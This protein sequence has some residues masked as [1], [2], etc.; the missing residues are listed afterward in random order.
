MYLDCP[1]PI[2]IERSNGAGYDQKNIK[3]MTV[4]GD[5]MSDFGSR[6]A[7]M[8]K[9]V[10]YPHSC[11]A[12][13]GSTFNHSNNNWQTLLRQSVGVFSQNSSCQQIT[14]S[15]IGGGPSLIK[16]NDLN[17]SYAFGGALTGRNTYFDVLNS[18]GQFPSKLLKPPYAV[19]K[20]GIRSQ[21]EHSFQSESPD[22]S[23]QLA[24]IWG[25]GN[26]LLAAVVRQQDLSSAFEQILNNSKA[27]LI[28]LLRNSN[29]KTVLI[30]SGAPT[31]GIVDGVSYALPY[32]RD[33]PL[34]WQEQIQSGA[35]S[36]LHDKT[37]QMAE[38]VKKM[39][40]YATII[41]FNNE[42]E[43]NWNRFG[44]KLGNFRQYGIINTTDPAQQQALL[45]QKDGILYNQLPYAQLNHQC[46][47]KRTEAGFLYFNSLHPTESGHRMLAKAIELT[48]EEHQAEIK[49][50]VTQAVFS[51]KESF[52]I[53][54]TGNDLITSST[55]SSTLQGVEGNDILQ[56]SAG[57]DDLQ[58]GIGND[59]L[60]GKGGSNRLIGGLGA[61]VFVIGLKSLVDGTQVIEDFNSEEGDRILLSPALSELVGDPFFVPT[62]EE[63]GKALTIESSKEG[64]LRIVISLS[65]INK[66]S[67]VVILNNVN[68]LDLNALS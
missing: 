52:S 23:A 6:A 46:Q 17:P 39:F 66:N 4:F 37:H 5:S 3:G 49:S 18:N 14:N 40:P 19:S 34:S 42:Y 53:G 29:A 31:I 41:P 38:A 57:D 21:I 9:H 54:T 1:A 22:L 11:P 45:D 15:L 64:S 30:S 16:A 26:D 28:S 10:L 58:G 56:G 60:D 2:P 27:N 50:S 68:T 32:L 43:Y 55:H 48:L 62:P 51:T 20:L 35:A 61:D 63:W 25:G 13:S 67:G 47:K 33:L 24:V 44:V 7:A 59:K 8:Y 36:V 12:W 65:S